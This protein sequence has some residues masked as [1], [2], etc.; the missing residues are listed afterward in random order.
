[1]SPDQKTEVATA[2]HEDAEVMSN[3][4][5]TQLLGGVPPEVQQEII[6]INTEARP[7]ALQVALFV[8]LIAGLIGLILSFMMMRLPDP[9]A[10]S[11]AEEMVLG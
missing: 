10:S 6:R 5:L 9:V 8:P 4:Q 11:A 7:I 1:L 2:L 3:T